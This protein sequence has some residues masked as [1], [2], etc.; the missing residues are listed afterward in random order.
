MGSLISCDLC[1]GACYSDEFYYSIENC[2][3]YRENRRFIWNYTEEESD[4]P[5][6]YSILIYKNLCQFERFLAAVWRPQNVYCVHVDKSS[7]RELLAG[8]RA[9]AS[10]FPNVFLTSRQVDVVWGK[11]VLDADL[12]CMDELLDARWR[13]NAFGVPWKYFVNTN[14]HE[15]PLK[16]NRQM[17]RILRSLAGANSVHMAPEEQQLFLRHLRPPFPVL[18]NKGE[19]HIVGCR[20]FI[21]FLRA[22]QTMRNLTDWIQRHTFNPGET[23]Y[24]TANFNYPAIAAPGA[25]TGRVQI[26]PSNNLRYGYFHRYKQWMAGLEPAHGTFDRATGCGGRWYYLCLFGVADLPRLT[27]ARRVVA[28]FVN[29]LYWDFQP[30]AYDCLEQWH[31]NR[32]LDEIRGAQL[33]MNFAYYKSID[34]VRNHVTC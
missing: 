22:N 25:Y 34:S 30:H 26:R 23:L 5:I 1:A 21:E 2:T 16:T 18:L 9:I 28:L 3:T 10:C 24:A 14:A 8:A 33:D 20:A 31:A 29:K 27:N 6:A 7:R 13:R 4:F 32:T 17:V 15:F 19:T 12:L 11:T